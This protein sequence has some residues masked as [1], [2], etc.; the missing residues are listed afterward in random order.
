MYKCKIC[1]AVCHGQMNKHAILRSNGQIA[2]ELPVCLECKRQ[3]G[4]GKSPA[5]LA[6]IVAQRR[7]APVMPIEPPAK[8]I[9]EVEPLP[10]QFSLFGEP[11]TAEVVDPFESTPTLPK[12]KKGKTKKQRKEVSAK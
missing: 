12:V 8:V 1:E 3:L 7:A 5:L 4:D 11:L 6:A 2:K 9:N 10:M